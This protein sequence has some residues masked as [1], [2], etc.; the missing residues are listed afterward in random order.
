VRLFFNVTK[1]LGGRHE[2]IIEVVY[3]RRRF[4]VV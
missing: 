3:K 4:K 1:Q 2:Y